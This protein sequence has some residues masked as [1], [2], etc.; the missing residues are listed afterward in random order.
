MKK[1][2]SRNIHL[3]G[4]L[5]LIPAL[6]SAQESKLSE[7][8]AIASKTGK[9]IL[10][11]FYADWCSP[12]RELHAEMMNNIQLKS[13]LDLHYFKMRVNVDRQESQLLSSRYGVKSIPSLVILDDQLR[14]ISRT[15][16]FRNAARIK[17]FLEKHFMDNA[18]PLEHYH[19]KYKTN[20][21]A[22]FLKEYTQLLWE[23]FNGKY[24]RIAR[25]YINTQDDIYSEENIDFIRKYLCSDISSW[26][27]KEL[28]KNREDLYEMM[29]SDVLDQIFIDVIMKSFDLE[30]EIEKKQC[31][32]LMID[33]FGED[34]G[35]Y[36]F[37]RERLKDVT[38]YAD[39][40][41]DEFRRLARD[42]TRYTQRTDWDI[43]Y[44]VGLKLALSSRNDADR[45]LAKRYALFAVSK[46]RSWRTL[47]LLSVLAYQAGEKTVALDLVIEASEYA[48]KEDVKYRTMIRHLDD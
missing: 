16:G 24:E 29:D 27:F 4:Y 11:D 14:E 38:M 37:L 10:L 22:A 20:R 33:L 3:L 8:Q 21:G 12:C 19:E 17:Y 9:L 42:F 2:H 35:G 5:L 48:L 30:S 40:V 45:A 7:L 39:F 36:H 28:H 6:C 44:D 23:N 32:A 13:V 41:P 43:L 34:Q 25:E 18:D 1:V 47:D 26:G 31:K 15:T 46:N